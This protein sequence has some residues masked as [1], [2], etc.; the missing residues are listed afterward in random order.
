VIADTF[1]QA[2]EELPEQASQQRS[3]E[4]HPLVS[5][6]ISVIQLPPSQYR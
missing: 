2:L 5:E 1:G 4:V 3:G 6:M